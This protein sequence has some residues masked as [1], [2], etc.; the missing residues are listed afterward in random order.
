[1]WRVA[2]LEKSV[3]KIGIYKKF[4][5]APAAIS[6]PAAKGIDPPRVGTEDRTGKGPEDLTG[7]GEDD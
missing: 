3:N 2:Y 6:P 1:M 4:G 5:C 7:E